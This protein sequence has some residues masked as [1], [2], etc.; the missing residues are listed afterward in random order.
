MPEGS[1]RT[2]AVLDWS[3]A[4]CKRPCA[5]SWHGAPPERADKT[6]KSQQHVLFASTIALQSGHTDALEV[7]CDLR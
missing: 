7:R 1:P 5:K 2:L 4:D 6:R 3:V